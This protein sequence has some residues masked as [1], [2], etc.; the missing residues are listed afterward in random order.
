MT[1]MESQHL[2]NA[3]GST[4]WDII[5]DSGNLA[6]WDSGIASVSGVIRNGGVIRVR[7]RHG[8]RNLR[9]RVEQIP[10]EVMTWTRT[11][12]PGLG[13]TVRTFVLSQRGGMTLLLVR[14]EARGPLRGVIRSPF[15]STQRDLDEF[16]D[17]VRKR[18][19]LIG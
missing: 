2:I 19:E 8:G 18:A 3:R 7:T 13:A 11:V 16:V 9:V 12:P 17:A 1:P 6:V 10:G 15:S 4:V 5:T 14:D